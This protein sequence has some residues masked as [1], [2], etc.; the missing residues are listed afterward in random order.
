L[1]LNNFWQELDVLV[2]ESPLV[3]D[4]PKGSR[5]PRYP[6][7]IYPYD[8]GYLDSTRAAD[9]GCI[10]CWIGSLPDRSVSAVICAIDRHKQDAEIKLLLGCTPAEARE[11]LAVH[12]QGAQSALLVERP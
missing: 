8:Y 7:M 6:E 5:H 3:I 10:D 4:R 12:N 11:I 9:G 2:A 1:D